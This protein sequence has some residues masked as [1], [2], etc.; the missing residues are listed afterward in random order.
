MKPYRILTI[1]LLGGLTL[2]HLWYISSGVLDLAP[3]ESHYWEWSRRL[4]WSYYSKGPLVA[5]LIAAS[6]SLGGNTDFFVRLPAVLLALGTAVPAY[7]LTK[8]LFLSDRAAFLAVV[9]L[10]LLPLYSAGSILM[11]IDAPFVFFW[12]LALFA[13]HQAIRSSESTAQ[14]Q[15]A[16]DCHGPRATGHGPTGVWWGLFGIALGLGFLS[17]YTMLL[18]LPCLAVYLLRS[19]LGYGWLRKKELPFAL[20]LSSLFTIPVVVWNVRHGWVSFRHVLGQAGL[21]GGEE[22]FSVKTFLEF[23]GS[24]AGVASPFL[25]LVLA[26]AMIRSGRLGLREGRDEHLFLFSF[27]VPVLAFFL[28]WSFYEKVQANWAAP[29]YLAAAIALAGWGDKLLQKAHDRKRKRRLVLTFSVIF[30]PGFLLVAVGHFPTLV[31]SLGIDLPP[32]ADPT[33]RLQGWRELGEAVGKILHQGGGRKPPAIVS[34]R[35]Q[36]ASELAF[37]VPG[38]PQVFNVNLGRRLNQY[39]IW[40]GLETL[41]GRDILFVT[42]D[43]GEAPQEIREACEGVKKAEV[44]RTLHRGHPAYTFSIFHCK[45]LREV[46]ARQGR[47]RY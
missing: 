12:A 40:G 47:T 8:R 20:L 18:L 6:T 7:L 14:D 24:Q 46:P 26:G 36:I 29:A 11:T 21:A 37:Y 23:L 30:L 28:L 27:S 9:V 16:S 17:K 35:Y 4:D 41:E 2:F 32:K 5:Y 1:V 34:D 31:D 44:V 13:L 38:H 19:P 15:K 42:Y 43:D 25:F 10:S 39:D 33:M 3:D 22:H 45:N